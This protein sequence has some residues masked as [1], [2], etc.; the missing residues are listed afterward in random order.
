MKLSTITRQD[1]ENIR[2]KIAE[3]N[4]NSGVFNFTDNSG[5]GGTTVNMNGG[6][7][8]DDA[9]YVGSGRNK[10]RL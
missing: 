4:R 6:E 5:N 9:V 8:V 7:R 3:D 1:L 10:R 2:Q